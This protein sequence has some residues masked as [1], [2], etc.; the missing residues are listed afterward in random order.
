MYGVFPDAGY[1]C[2]LQLPHQNN[3]LVALL[4]LTHSPTYTALPHTKLQPAQT[5]QLACIQLPANIQPADLK[6]QPE[7]ALEQNLPLLYA[8]T[9]PV[10]PPCIPAV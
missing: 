7:V 3:P 8:Q 10:P 6:P 5:L 4:N 2:N 9:T 1:K